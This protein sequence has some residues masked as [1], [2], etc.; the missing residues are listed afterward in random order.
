MPS[1][2]LGDRDSPRKKS[3]MSPVIEEF[4]VRD[5]KEGVKR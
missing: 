1:R 5:G 2:E 3:L 4:T